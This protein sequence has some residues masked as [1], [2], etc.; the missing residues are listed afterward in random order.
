LKIHDQ[1][2]QTFK[3]FETLELSRFFTRYTTMK[4]TRLYTDTVNELHCEDIEA[5]LNNA[6]KISKL[7]EKVNA[8][9][10]RFSTGDR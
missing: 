2:S 5:E 9:V 10:R 7:S 3:V 8:T 6:G 1:I 4:I